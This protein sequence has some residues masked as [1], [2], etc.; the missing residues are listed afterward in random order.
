[1]VRGQCGIS[2]LAIHED[3]LLRLVDEKG[4]NLSMGQRQLMCMAR[5]LLRPY[6]VDSSCALQRRMLSHQLIAQQL[7]AHLQLA[8]CMAR[9]A[10]QAV[11]SSRPRRGH[12]ECRL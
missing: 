8:T 3:G 1:M 6:N 4:S 12:R 7:V 10:W 5:A 9:R 2:G 11:A